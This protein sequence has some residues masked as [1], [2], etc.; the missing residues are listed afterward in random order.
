MEENMNTLI[1]D[2][3]QKGLER[4]VS[5]E[6]IAS[7]LQKGGWSPREIAEA[8]DAFVESELPLAVPRKRVS[9]RPK[10]TFLFLMLFAPLYMAA[11]AL[12]SVLFDLINL[13][14]PASNQNIQY[15]IVSL[16]YGIACV[17]V[18]FPVFLWMHTLIKREAARNP[19]QRIS[20]VRRW[21]TYLTLFIAAISIVADLITLIVTFL[22]GEITVRFLLK[23]LVIAVM[24]AGAFV[25]Y[26]RDLRHDEVAPSAEFRAGH[27]ARA[28]FAALVVLVLATTVT[29]FWFA[30]SPFRARTEKQDAQRVADLRDIARSVEAFYGWKGRLPESLD[31]CDSNPITFVDQKSDR[32][33]REPY[34]YRV[35]SDTSF[36]LGAVFVLPSREDEPGFWKHGSGMNTFRI[37]VTKNK[38]AAGN[39]VSPFLY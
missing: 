23:V 25:Y 13:T 21:L 20:P 37:D 18:A 2:F 16:R 26:L 9:S 8:L 39:P 31:E 7:E 3:V 15:S 24:A 11:F 1:S 22:E 5:R 6:Q 17:V 38:G 28:G 14:F 4:G 36:Q 34:L 27:T 10:E 29:A 33:T 30:G 12:G 19:G 32:I 35:I